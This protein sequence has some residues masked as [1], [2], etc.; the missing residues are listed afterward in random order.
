[1]TAAHNQSNTPRPRTLYVAFELGANQWKLAFAVEAADN[2]RTRVVN[3]RDTAKSASKN[4]FSS[5]DS[6]EGRSCSSTW[7]TVYLA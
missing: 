3:D 1:M 2:P 7:A 6:D 5:L 4:N